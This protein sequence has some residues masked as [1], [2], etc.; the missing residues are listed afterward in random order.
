MVE[1]AT[2]LQVAAVPVMVCV[3]Q[4]DLNVP[5]IGAPEVLEIVKV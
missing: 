1:T 2:L 4:P 3:Q 5:Y